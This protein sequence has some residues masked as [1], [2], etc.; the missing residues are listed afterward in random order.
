MVNSDGK[1]R[2]YVALKNCNIRLKEICYQRN[3]EHIVILA[4]QE[5]IPAN[6][7]KRGVKRIR[8][9]QGVSNLDGTI[10]QYRVKNNYD[11]FNNKKLILNL[12]N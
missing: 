11:E 8:Y 10:I 2:G 6:Y 4:N 5:S 12:N 3:C 9:I 1:E 7:R